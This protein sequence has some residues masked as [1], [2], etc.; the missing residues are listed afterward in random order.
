[1]QSC[2]TQKSLQI[3]Q[4]L[5]NFHNSRREI[6]PLQL[7]SHVKV[8]ECTMHNSSLPVTVLLGFPAAAWLFVGET[9]ILTDQ[10]LHCSVTSVSSF[11]ILNLLFLPLLD[12]SCLSVGAMGS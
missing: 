5:S 8:V 2:V 11:V 6:I 9:L 12:Y 1:M 3:Y 7:L 10:Y 4:I